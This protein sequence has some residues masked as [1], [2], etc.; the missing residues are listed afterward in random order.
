MF[1]QYPHYHVKNTLA[2]G[3]NFIAGYRAF[4]GIESRGSK[5]DY[6]VL[7][8]WQLFCV[9]DDTVRST[10]EYNLLHFASPATIDPLLA[11]LKAHNCIDEQTLKMHRMYRIG[12]G[13]VLCV[14]FSKFDVMDFENLVKTAFNRPVRM[15][16]LNVED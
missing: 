10:M 7:Q 14:S 3:G 9:A 13:T 12:T 15:E 1:A 2:K 4:C 16:V 11:E 5:V 6:Q 8:S